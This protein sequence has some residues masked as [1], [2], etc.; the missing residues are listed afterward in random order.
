[1]NMDKQTNTPFVAEYVGLD[2]FDNRHRYIIRNNQGKLLA[3][4]ADYDKDV[5]CVE[6][7]AL[8]AKCN[9]GQ[10]EPEFV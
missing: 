5:A 4:V 6:A 9:G 1:M 8:V 3:S 2:K 7:T 10:A